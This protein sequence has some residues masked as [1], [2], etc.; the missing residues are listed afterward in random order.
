MPNTSPETHSNQPGDNSGNHSG[1]NPAGIPLNGANSASGGPPPNGPIGW[2]VLVPGAPVTSG[3]LTV[4]PIQGAE[5]HTPAYTLL[6]EAIKHEQ[7]VVMEISEGGNVPVLL[8]DNRSEKPILAIQGEE[9][10]GAK[11]NRT[12]NVS[13]LA[14]QGKTEIP[15]TCIEAGRWGYRGRSFES[16][17]FEHYKLRQAKAAM[18][19]R[20]RKHKRPERPR[21]ES[22]GADQGAVWE[23]MDCQLAQHSV[24]S[25]T[26]SMSDVYAD[27]SVRSR[28]DRFDVGLKLP[29]ATRGVVVAFGQRVVSAEIF[30]CPAVFQKLW[31]RI[32]RSYAFTAMNELAHH[33]GHGK[34][35]AGTNGG[36]TLEQAEAFLLEPCNAEAQPEDSVGLG[37]DVRWETDG[38]LACSLFHEG[39]MLH[40]TVYARG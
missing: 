38:F 17:G 10:I 40:G 35:Q 16:G 9:L 24:P 4:F 12:L 15:V 20:S 21:V 27:R 31:P 30:E 7:A 39:R 29:E 34:D 28:L 1:N 33:Q 6:A 14:A 11:Q 37:Q 36:P 13:I 8:L 26:S 23:E 25:P 18:V 19:S 5:D 32:L 22:Y 2:P 3:P